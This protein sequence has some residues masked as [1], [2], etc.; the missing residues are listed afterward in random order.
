MKFKGGK[1]WIACALALA[2]AGAPATASAQE[3]GVIGS[4]VISTVVVTA[5]VA[6]TGVVILVSPFILTTSVAGEAVM[7]DGTKAEQYLREHEYGVREALAMGEGVLV[8]DLSSAIGL[9]AKE[10]VRLGKVLRTERAEL[11]ALA[12]PSSLTKARA[13][14]FMHRTLEVIQSDPQLAAALARRAS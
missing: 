7:D 14:E 3:E 13:L 4:L 6:V 9:N 8:D 5:G 11:G 10:K 2:F 12:E 1:R